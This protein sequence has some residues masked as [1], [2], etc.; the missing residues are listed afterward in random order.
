[1][2]DIAEPKPKPWLIT[3][4][5]ASELGKLGA[6]ARWNPPTPTNANA[7]NPAH[8]RALAIVNKQMD[9]IDKL[10]DG[11]DLKPSDWRDLTMAR[12]RLFK[13]WQV[14]ANIPNPGNLKPT[15]PRTARPN[16]GPEAEP[17]PQ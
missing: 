4:E 11:K 16:S 3:K 8:V 2:S 5:T 6:L 7:N 10:L 17:I 13:Q 12:E 1:M 15:K 14:L 9:A